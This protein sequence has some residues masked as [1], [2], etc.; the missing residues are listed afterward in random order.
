MRADTLQDQSSS[1]TTAID[2]W[3][4]SQLVSQF[5]CFFVSQVGSF[6]RF[7]SS[8]YIYY[9]LSF[10]TLPPILLPLVRESVSVCLSSTPPCTLF[11][12]T[13]ASCLSVFSFCLFFL[14]FCFLVVAS[15]PST[16]STRAHHACVCCN[17]LFYFILEVCVVCVCALTLAA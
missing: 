1:D 6:P 13:S 17:L 3:P 10:L 14:S 4:V 7:I 16:P 5:V 2:L 12:H 11:T 8:F 9:I 15:P